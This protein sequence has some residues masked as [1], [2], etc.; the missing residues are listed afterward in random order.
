[1]A[2]SALTATL[3]AALVEMDGVEMMA[4]SFKAEKMLELF[5]KTLLR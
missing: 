4:G 3:K 5:L 2:E 1:M